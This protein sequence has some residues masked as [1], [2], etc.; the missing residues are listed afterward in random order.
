MI[1]KLQGHV[2]TFL[3][4]AVLCGP[5]V[6]A[7]LFH[8][9]PYQDRH[10]NLNSTPRTSD[11]GYSGALVDSGSSFSP[12][13][14]NQVRSGSTSESIGG[15]SKPTLNAIL[16]VWVPDELPVE[17]NGYPTRPQSLAG[18][19][20][21]SR[22]FSLEGLDVDRVSPCDIVIKCIDQ[23]G[24]TTEY[25]RALSVIGGG[26]YEVRF[27]RDFEPVDEDFS[28][29]EDIQQVPAP[30]NLGTENWSTP[31]SRSPDYEEPIETFPNDSELTTGAES[32]IQPAGQESSPS[33]DVIEILP[34]TPP[35]T[36]ENSQP[37]K[38][39]K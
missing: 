32:I 24:N 2:C 25:R 3:C 26:N 7:G 39:S 31:H 8:G 16:R 29:F 15:V 33:D 38:T 23:L 22:V 1:R 5:S 10:F 6:Q 36:K 18:I 14:G 21:N 20:S 12:N 34:G 27:P 30:V 4:V 19:H 37:S 13:Y 9:H 11:S 35:V 28:E 17:V